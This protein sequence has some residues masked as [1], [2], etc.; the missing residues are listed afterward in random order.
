MR[1]GKREE[2][3][4]ERG[5]GEMESKGKDGGGG[6]KHNFTQSINEIG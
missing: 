4:R 6:S 2:S 5:G 3:E 1:E